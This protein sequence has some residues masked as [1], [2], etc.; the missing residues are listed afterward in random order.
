MTRRFL[1]AALGG[2]VA[3]FVGAANGAPIVAADL[4]ARGGSRCCRGVCR[5]SETQEVSPACRGELRLDGV[6]FAFRVPAGVREDARVVVLFGGR[7]WTGSGTLDRF[8]WAE[9]ADRAGWVL[10]SPSFT[11][12]EYWDPAS[13]TGRLLLRAIGCLEARLGLKSRGLFLYGFSAG[14]QCA[15]LFAAFLQGRV[16]AWG[17]H[18]CGVYPERDSLAGELPPALLTCGREDTRRDV[19]TRRFGYVYREGGGACLRLTFPGGHAL[20]PEALKLACAWFLARE[21]GAPPAA[22]GDDDSGRTLPPGRAKEIDIEFRNPLDG[23]EVTD[24]WLRS[25]KG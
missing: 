23:G 3:C 20:Q 25:H 10:L 12:G 17:A 13:G 6:G 24:L 21:K 5:S 18:A 15:A 8:G 14:G 2:C 1:G 16:D 4:A 22:F 19:L 9:A 11:S 7:G